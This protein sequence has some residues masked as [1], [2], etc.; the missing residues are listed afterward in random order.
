MN[1][2]ELRRSLL[3]KTKNCPWEILKLLMKIEPN[4][5]ENAVIT[6]FDNGMSHFVLNPL[7]NGERLVGQALTK[8]F[9]GGTKREDVFVLDS[10]QPFGSRASDVEKYLKFSLDNTGLEYFDMYL[11]GEPWTALRDFTKKVTYNDFILNANG[12][13]ALDFDADQITTWKAMEAQVKAGLIKSIGLL[14]FN[15]KQV[16][17]LINNSEIKPSY[18]AVS[19]YLYNQEK[20]LRELCA[21]H[22]IVVAS[23]APSGCFPSAMEQFANK[24]YRSLPNPMNDPVVLELSEK[25]G[26]TSEQIL[27]RHLHQEGVVLLIPG[28]SEP[29]R[30]KPAI[31]ILDF[32]LSQDELSQLDNLDRGEDGRFID[33]YNFPG[34]AEHPEY[35]YSTHL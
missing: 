31:D 18:L 29:E 13:I 7:M 33:D 32:E 3:Q 24:N 2:S 16:L 6:A 22:N 5:L 14:N 15:E 23:W 17:K 25:Y 12:T 4:A 1:P 11:F 26:K 34:V 19:M 10:V 27:L 30:V 9:Q 35:P 28:L 8:I 20:G 21:K